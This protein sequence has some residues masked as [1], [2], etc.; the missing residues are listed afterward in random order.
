MFKEA[1]EAYMEGI[2]LLME[3]KKQTS[4]DPVFNEKVK[5]RIKVMLD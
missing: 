5:A 3:I 2:K 1:K 4:D